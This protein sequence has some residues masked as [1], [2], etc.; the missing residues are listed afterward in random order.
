MR[1]PAVPFFLR[2]AADKKSNF[3]LEVLDQSTADELPMLRVDKA[4]VLPAPIGQTRLTKV[5]YETTDDQ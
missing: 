1:H 2:Y 4:Q 3:N 5:R